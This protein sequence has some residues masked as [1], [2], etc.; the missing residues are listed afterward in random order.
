MPVKRI[1]LVATHFTPHV[2]GVE[3]Y[4][5]DLVRNIQNLYPDVLMTV[6]TL[7]TAGGKS[8][9]VNDHVTVIRVP[10]WGPDVNPFFSLS[11]TKAVLKDINLDS[12]DVVVTQCRYYFFVN[13]ITALVKKTKV[14]LVHIEHNGDYMTHSNPLIQFLA[15]AY[16][17]FVSPSVLRRAN[18]IIA[19][20]LKVKHF[21]ER[22]FTIKN[23]ELVYGGV[24]IV[25]WPYR[26]KLP[27]TSKKR[28]FFCG[29]L[30]ESKGVYVLLEAF[31]KISKEFP[32]STLSYV[33]TGMEQENLE[34]KIKDLGLESQV[35]V[36]G[37]KTQAEIKEYYKSA[38]IFVNPSH[39]SEGLQ[40][41]V[42]EAGASGI[43]IIST[44]CDGVEEL[45]KSRQNGVLVP[46]KNSKAL[47]N[48]LRALLSDSEV[49]ERYRLN[50]R[51]EIEV[52][53]S[54]ANNT[55]VLY[56]SLFI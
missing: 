46:Q 2:G 35:V 36:L 22:A 42:L 48:E 37:K 1:L 16:D 49:Q 19:I 23:V 50:M 39:H 53:F 41:S 27:E 51:K 28:I 52:H 54:L 32:Q 26:E 14:R 44:D 40:R 13:Y 33:G 34:K 17:R 4:T 8:K 43:P 11:K 45:I 21:I 30:I 47:A 55:K 38:T 15:W 56:E 6:L 7:N 18:H 3:V 29:R 10:A 24:N 20:S 9:E 12:F 5:Q 25:D 31:A